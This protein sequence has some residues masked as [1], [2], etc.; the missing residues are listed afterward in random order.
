MGVNFCAGDSNSCQEQQII[1]HSYETH[2]K[3]NNSK[4]IKFS[5]N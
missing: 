2:K 4:T 3:V 1:G 5:I